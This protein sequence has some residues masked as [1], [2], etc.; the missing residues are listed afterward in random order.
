MTGKQ[1]LSTL[2]RS[3]RR[4]RLA[5]TGVI[6]LF[7]LV[8]IALLA[9]FI[10]PYDPNEITFHNA[11][12][13]IWQRAAQWQPAREIGTETLAGVTLRV[14]GT[15]VAVGTSGSSL[16]F[17]GKD[18]HTLRQAVEENLNAVASSGGLTVAV[19]QKGVI[20]HSDDTST[21]G[22]W[23]QIASPTEEELLGVALATR[24]LGVAVGR[25]GTVLQWDGRQWS[26]VTSGVREDLYG[27]SLL[28]DGFGF[29]VGARSTVLGFD[30]G[31]LTRQ[32]VLGFRDFY[33]V[34]ILDRNTA[35][36]VGERGTIFSYNGRMWSQMFG[37]ETRDLSDVR[38]LSPSEALAIGTHGVVMQLQSGQWRRVDIDYRRNL[39][40]LDARDGDVLIVGTDPYV[41]EL[42]TPSRNHLFG[43]TH[44]GRDIFSQTIYGSRT[45]L[46]VGI[47]A[48]VMVTII[49]TNVGLVAGYFRGRVDNVLM[50]I[51][52][53]MY[54]LPFE[55]FAMVLVMIFR[56]S[57]TIVIL[58]VGLLT[59]RSTARI[60]RAQV[61]SLANRPFVKAARIAGASHL[62]TLY[63]HIAPNVLP[64]ALLQLA[65]SMAFAITA[66]A[67]LSFLGLGPPQTHSWGT[68]L[69]A[70]RLSGAWRIAWWWVIPPGLL[71]MIT[72]VSVFF[73]SRALEVITNPRLEGGDQDAA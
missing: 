60:I 37:S 72:V 22:G 27:A 47:L 43:T 69:H 59:W 10:A 62:R 3:L 30:G 16:A 52:D 57:L 61:L 41:N 55:P 71:I 67:T 15:A 13:A 65:V 40:S 39:R 56:P 17:D 19:G 29:I 6:I 38:M 21:D 33:G 7:A 49:G 70:A 54:A 5:L 1:F 48:A 35:V 31:R 8:V 36:A 58:A 68:I 45:A 18:W 73:V 4:D 2:W 64:L 32:N 28:A 25:A 11:G 20:V 26:E 50:R 66:E 46:L 24:D 51:V 42:A 44:L 12:V 23:R 34:H 63:V 14:D 53:V 9:P